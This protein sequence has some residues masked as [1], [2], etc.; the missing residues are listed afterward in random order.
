MVM[1]VILFVAMIGV[2]V[3][4]PAMSFVITFMGGVVVT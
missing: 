4:F 3:A 1:V 2:D